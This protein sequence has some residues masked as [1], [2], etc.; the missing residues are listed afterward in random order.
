MLYPSHIISKPR[1]FFSQEI[2]EKKLAINRINTVYF[3]DE[4][5][6]TP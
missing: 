2:R 3:E 4:L 5:N 1:S 6:F